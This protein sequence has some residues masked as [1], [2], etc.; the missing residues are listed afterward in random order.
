MNDPTFGDVEE[1]RTNS[2]VWSQELDAKMKRWEAKHG[3]YEEM[4][5]SFKA[6]ELGMRTC[7]VCSQVCK[8]QH[9]MD[10]R[11]RNSEACKKRV[12]TQ[13]G[14]LYIPKSHEMVT[15]S[16]GYRLFR[17]NLERHK[18]GDL[19]KNNLQRKAG[20]VCNLCNYIAKGSRPKRDFEK[21]C[22]GKR[23]LLKIARLTARQPTN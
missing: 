10:Y 3:T 4:Q 7:P 8:T 11:H 9:H 1:L 16:C 21:H 15:C 19:H 2:L 18:Q 17:V 5:R 23:H 13:R 12:A 20:F 22:L 6:Q 14:C